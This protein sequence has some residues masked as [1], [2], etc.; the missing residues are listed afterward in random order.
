MLRIVSVTIACIEANL[1]IIHNLE[2]TQWKNESISMPRNVSTTFLCIDV[3]PKSIRIQMKLVMKC[4]FLFFVR[5]SMNFEK[6]NLCQCRGMCPQ[7]FY[8][9]MNSNQ[10]V[11]H[12]STIVESPIKM[13][14]FQCREVYPQH[15]YVSMSNQS[16]SIISNHPLK[17]TY[18]NA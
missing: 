15:F 9:S 16:K 14:L 11:E 17:W 7:H 5:F 13:N 2:L 12:Q 6:M 10:K 4:P 8:V 3:E 18:F 1:H